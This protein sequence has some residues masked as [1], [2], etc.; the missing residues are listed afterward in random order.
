MYFIETLHLILCYLVYVGC[1][2]NT[3]MISFSAFE[4]MEHSKSISKVNL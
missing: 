4:D 3:R 2:M 1:N